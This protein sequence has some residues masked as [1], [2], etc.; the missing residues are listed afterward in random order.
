MTYF[1]VFS[2]RCNLT[3]FTLHMRLSTPV[4]ASGTLAQK[5]EAYGVGM[6]TMNTSLT[7]QMTVGRSETT[8]LTP[9]LSCRDLRT[10]RASL[11]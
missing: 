10:S 4:I 8:G 6:E 9:E 3:P 2:M 1:C 7:G 11:R 5:V